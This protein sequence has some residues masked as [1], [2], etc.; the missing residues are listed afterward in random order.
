MTPTSKRCRLDC[1]SVATLASPDQHAY[2]ASSNTMSL[3]IHSS[4]STARP[5]ALAQAV[6]Q[7]RH[8]RNRAT[9]QLEPHREELLRLAEA[10]DSAETLAIGLGL[11]GI[12]IGRE[13]MRRWLTRELGRRPARRSK[14]QR[15]V[16]GSRIGAISTPASPVAARSAL[17][18]AATTEGVTNSPTPPVIP[19]TPH[20]GPARSG[21]DVPVP[22]G[23]RFILPGETPLQALHRR[24]AE[25]RASDGA[26]RAPA[27]RPLEGQGNKLITPPA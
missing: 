14:R 18:P 24:V 19:R 6:A 15:P 26:E 3:P 20:P 23:T 22:E 25:R 17:T 7:A 16:R 10:G 9:A 13:T 1:A 27:I 21:A 5:T 8:P 2:H 11:I 4:S 12:K